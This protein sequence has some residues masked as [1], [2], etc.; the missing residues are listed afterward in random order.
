MSNPLRFVVQQQIAGTYTYKV[1]YPTRNNFAAVNIFDRETMWAPITAEQL[2]A[3][4]DK[5]AILKNEEAARKVQDAENNQN[6]EDKNKP[7]STDPV[8]ADN[9]KSAESIKESI[10]QDAQ[11][12][13]PSDAT[14][15]EQGELGPA[16][17][18]K[19]GE[20]DQEFAERIFLG[21]GA[22]PS[23]VSEQQVQVDKFN[24]GK[25]GGSGASGTYESN[26][27]AAARESL[28][29][30]EK[31]SESQ[32]TIPETT[33]ITPNIDTFNLSLEEQAKL[34]EAQVSQNPTPANAQSS[35]KLKQALKK[36]YNIE[37][38]SEAV[39]VD[40]L[41]TEAINAA[42]ASSKIYQKY[43][44]TAIITSAYDSFEEHAI[45]SAH[46][47]GRAIDLQTQRLGLT[48]EEKIS[49]ANDIQKELNNISYGY[50]VLLEDRGG[51]SE[52]IHIQ[53]NGTSQ[54]DVQR[55]ILDE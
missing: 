50:T 1:I 4:K 52:H 54:D 18:K 2:Q 23:A 10:K 12:S 19:P 32:A 13:A 3:N 17:Q 44:K 7:V 48:P 8:T 16:T 11:T 28:A 46:R 24:G 41:K 20:T 5:E 27:E 30:E 26:S 21:S 36:Y 29:R 45:N 53:F 14:R 39:N 49:I 51:E 47:D 25:S 42:I 6:L 40:A 33:I 55:N 35:G 31:L 22:E 15:V 9:I 34:A 38:K 43:K 37:T